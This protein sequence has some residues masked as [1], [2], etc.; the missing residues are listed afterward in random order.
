MGKI[1]VVDCGRTNMRA[2]LLSLEGETLARVLGTE[3]DHTD[4][5]TISQRLL[6][7]VSSLVEQTGGVMSEILVAVG[8]LAG[9]G[10][11]EDCL[12][13]E[14]ALKENGSSFPWLVESDAHQTLRAA[15][16]DG[17]VAVSL[18]GTGSAFFARDA[19]GT[20]HRTGGHGAILEDYGSAYEISRQAVMAMMRCYDGMGPDSSVFAALAEITGSGDPLELR[21]KLAWSGSSPSELAKLAPVVLQHAEQGDVVSKRILDRQLEKVVDCLWAL[22]HKAILPYGAPIFCSGGMVEKSPYYLER[23]VEV[24]TKGLPDNPCGLIEYEPCWGGWLLARRW[25][26]GKSR[27]SDKESSTG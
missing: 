18:L 2:Y 7:L 5:Q 10:R 15:R 21:S 13:L 11:E 22:I 16:E 6:D 14:K 1:I 4:P 23:V 19:S 3:T 12:K 20:V 25:L 8:G 26:E 27:D 24:V 17:A 9:Y